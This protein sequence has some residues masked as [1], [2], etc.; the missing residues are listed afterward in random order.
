MLGATVVDGLILL[1]DG[2]VWADWL[3]VTGALELGVRVRLFKWIDTVVAM[4]CGKCSWLV[5][6]EAWASQ[7]CADHHT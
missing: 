1:G 4:F 2:G 6:H 7:S 5:V 3:D